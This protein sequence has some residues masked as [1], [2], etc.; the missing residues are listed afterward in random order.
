MVTAGYN[1][2][3]PYKNQGVLP[4]WLYADLFRHLPFY[5]RSGTWVTFNAD[6]DIAFFMKLRLME[7]VDCFL[8]IN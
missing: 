4:E 6:C 2:N 7:D 5:D 3:R 1:P 8:T